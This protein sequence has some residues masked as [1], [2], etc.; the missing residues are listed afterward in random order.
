MLQRDARSAFLLGLAIC[1]AVTCA[2]A[3]HVPEGDKTARERECRRKR[4]HRRKTRSEEAAGATAKGAA[5]RTGACAKANPKLG[6]GESPRRS[7]SSSSSD[8]GISSA[9]DRSSAEDTS[10]PVPYHLRFPNVPSP[11]FEF[12]DTNGESVKVGG[13]AVLV[14]EGFLKG[15]RVFDC[16]VE[17]HPI[18]HLTS[19]DQRTGVYSC[20]GQSRYGE[21]E[22]PIHL[23]QALAE[24]LTTHLSS[25]TCDEIRIIHLDVGNKARL[26][27]QPGLDTIGRLGNASRW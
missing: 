8:I 15:R 10:A 13:R 27:R 11:T 7:S 4:R 14:H 12:E 20:V 6:R 19:F 25:Q 24:H 22:V 9:S 2:A 26:L 17:G 5:Q 21:G 18:S 16:R 3:C 23:R 1:G